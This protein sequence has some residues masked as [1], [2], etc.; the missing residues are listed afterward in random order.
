AIL[1]EVERDDHTAAAGSAARDAEGRNLRVFA[2]RSPVL[3]K[4]VEHIILARLAF[5]APPQTISCV[6]VAFLQQFDKFPD[7][8][9]LRVI[10]QSEVEPGRH[11]QDDENRQKNQPGPFGALFVSLSVTVQITWHGNDLTSRDTLYRRRRSIRS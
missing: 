2:L 8:G 7:L 6:V 1:T 9:F 5:R 4:F 10:P 3:H 11:N